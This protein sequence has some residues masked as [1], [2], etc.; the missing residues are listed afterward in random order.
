VYTETRISTK[1]CAHHRKDLDYNAT[2]RTTMNLEQTRLGESRQRYNLKIFRLFTVL[3]SLLLEATNKISPG[4]P[5]ISSL[6]YTLH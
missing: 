5:R 3:Y 4:I 6:N 2:A 1:L